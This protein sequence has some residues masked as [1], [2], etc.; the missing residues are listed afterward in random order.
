[1]VHKQSKM[2]QVMMRTPCLRYGSANALHPKL[3]VIVAR[4]PGV[5]LL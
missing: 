2:A 3:G 4:T 5:A 1:M